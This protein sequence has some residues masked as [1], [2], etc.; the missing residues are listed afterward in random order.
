MTMLAVLLLAVSPLNDNGP[1]DVDTPAP[2][3]AENMWVREA[4]PGANVM[5]AYGT[6]CNDGKEAV[7]L[8]AA[9]SVDFDRIEMHMTIESES[10]ITMER[11]ANLVIGS[12]DCVSFTPGGRHFMLL[13]PARA[14]HSGDTVMFTLVFANG[15]EMDI[16]F[17][18]RHAEEILEEQ[19]N[20]GGH[21]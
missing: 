7:T 15:A 17:P 1:I 6:F 13:D 18:V 2:L 19:H 21:H 12:R 9:S 3:R 14:L 10:S 11:F 20:H 8:A 5:A 16:A 4:P